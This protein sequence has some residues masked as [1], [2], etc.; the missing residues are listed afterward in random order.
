[1]SKKL[2]KDEFIEKAKRIHKHKYD[3]SEVVYKDWK[4]KV[5]IIDEF[6]YKHLIMPNGLLNGNKLSFTNLIDKNEYLINKFTQIHGDKY[7]YSLINCINIKEKII[8]KCLKHGNFKQTVDNH[9]KGKGC[10]RCNGKNRTTEIIIDEFNLVHGNK[11]DYSKVIY[12]GIKSKIKIICPIHNEFEQV[13]ETH[14][15]GSGCPICKESWGEREI[16]LFLDR[17]NILYNSQHKFD[18]CVHI[19]KLPFDFYLPEHNICVEFQGEQHFKPVNFFGGAKM[20]EIRKIRDKIKEEFCRNNNIRLV[21]IRYDVPLCT[22][23]EYLVQQVESRE[24]LF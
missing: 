2:T 19:L 6:G 4:T 10:P 11:Y 13:T 22:S 21:I 7:D 8:I 12:T 3:Y 17:H 16:R 20:F 23:L 14:L 18:D 9:M 15:E 1:M 5:I 24:E